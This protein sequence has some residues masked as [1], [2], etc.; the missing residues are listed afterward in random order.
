[1]QLQNVHSPLWLYRRIQLGGQE[2]TEA[3]LPVFTTPIR[4]KPKACTHRLQTVYNQCIP[5]QSIFSRQTSS[6]GK[7]ERK[8]KKKEKGGAKFPIICSLVNIICS[9]LILLKKQAFLCTSALKQMYAKFIMKT[10]HKTISGL[11]NQ[12]IIYTIRYIMLI[13]HNNSIFWDYL[14][15]E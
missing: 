11:F 5:L 4:K 6:Q 9:S 10:I 3:Q 14:Y 15:V 12:S 7:R 8:K 2:S 1:M 13:R